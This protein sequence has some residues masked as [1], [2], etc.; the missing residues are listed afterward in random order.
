MPSRQVL[1]HFCIRILHIAT[2]RTA[3]PR[4]KAMNEEEPLN[5]GTLSNAS[6]RARE[7]E[8][9]PVRNSG[10]CDLRQDF[11]IRDDWAELPIPKFAVLGFHTA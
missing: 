9:R 6:F 2:S 11:P 7:I 5:N 3:L 10:T 8:R 4:D 1:N